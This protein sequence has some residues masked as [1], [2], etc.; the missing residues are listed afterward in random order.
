MK[1]LLI[2][3]CPDGLRW[4]RDLVGQCVPFINDTGTEYRSREPAG[5]TNFVQYE[6]A[7]IVEEQKTMMQITEKKTTLLEN[8]GMNKVGY[9]LQD[10]EG[11]NAYV[12]SAAVRW[13][14]A[15]QRDEFMFPENKET[16]EIIFGGKTH[17]IK[18]ASIKLMAGII[19]Y[20]IPMQHETPTRLINDV[21][22]LLADAIDPFLY[23]DEAGHTR[24]KKQLIQLLQS[25]NKID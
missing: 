18:K 24:F 14:N 6:D 23:M 19:D 16:P 2:K 22:D 25:E 12:E 3:Q 5:Y 10:A 15:K 4:Y 9:I 13:L 7:E 20:K 21:L 1:A 11:K 17:N 8:S